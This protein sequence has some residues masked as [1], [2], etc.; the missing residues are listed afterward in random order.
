MTRD[1]A[2]HNIF[3]NSTGERLKAARYLSKSS[4]ISDRADLL[5]ALANEKVSY[6]RTSLGLAL[7]RL[8]K[9]QPPPNEAIGA[10][11][12]IEIP[13][14]VRNKFIRMVTEE[15]TGKILHEFASPVGLLSASAAREIPDFENSRTNAYIR[16]LQRVFEAIEYLRLAS[17]IP[18]REEVNISSLIS[19]IVNATHNNDGLDISQQGEKSLQVFTDQ[20]LLGLALSNGIRNA[21]EAATSA[22]SIE[23]YPI[24]I[25][26]GQTNVDYWIAV[27]DRGI[28]IVGPV[29]SAFEIG[30]TT[31]RNHSGFGL[32]IARQ[33][34]ETLGGTCTLQPVAGG[35]TRFEL[36]WE[37]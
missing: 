26:W 22:N 25:T 10:D 23:P 29:E 37:R 20:A 32:A 9:L 1:E 6:V 12:D 34:I 8:Q 28:G 7:N 24:I 15:V 4:E 18:K 13:I 33:A 27:I 17:S 36:R 35:G 16:N 5:K 3:S 31:K 11:S 14:E 21:I 19:E 2:L 30:K